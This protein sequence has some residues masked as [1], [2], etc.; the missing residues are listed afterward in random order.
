MK[1][2]LEK[3]PFNPECDQEKLE[4]LLEKGFNCSFR[5]FSI[6]AGDFR[7]NFERRT[8]LNMGKEILFL[9]ITLH[10]KGIQFPLFDSAVMDGKRMFS[11]QAQKVVLEAISHIMTAYSDFEENVKEMGFELFTGIHSNYHVMKMTGNGFEFICSRLGDSI[12]YYM[13]EYP[14]VGKTQIIFLPFIMG[15]KKL[16]EDGTSPSGF[17]QYEKP[18]FDFQSYMLESLHLQ[19]IFKGNDS[20]L[21]FMSFPSSLRD[22]I[23]SFTGR[24]FIEA[25]GLFSYNRR[26]WS[27]IHTENAWI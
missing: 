15:Y 2:F 7:I 13:K 21:D 23:L 18:G 17:Y 16:N 4:T 1:N 27:V 9:E 3:I 11:S 8:F 12:E 6:K 20:G 24:K 22:G 19:G 14:P 5:P 10:R 26:V 25:E